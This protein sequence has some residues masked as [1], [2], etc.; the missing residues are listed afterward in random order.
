MKKKKNQK[1]KLKIYTIIIILITLGV[2]Y[3]IYIDNK[4]KKEVVIEENAE[5]VRLVNKNLNQTYPETPREVVKLY[6]R[7]IIC[8]Y[9][10]EYTN[11]QLI[12]LTNQA[13][14]L[15]DEELIERNPYDEYFKR[16]CEEIESYKDIDQKISSCILESNREVD[17]Y[18]KEDKKMASVECV[19]YLK[20]DE[21][22][23]KVSHEYVLRKDEDGKWKI[24]Y[25]K[26]ADKE[27]DE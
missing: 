5:V 21:G 24:L 3:Y 6:N 11:N 26:L 10:E 20:G 2:M 14:T 18:T 9:N 4:P 25:W 17:Y 22:T 12:A 1:N 19:Y 16:L 15:F 8:F 7:I 27:D 23:I 13:R